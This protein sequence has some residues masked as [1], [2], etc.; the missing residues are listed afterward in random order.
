MLA[1]ADLERRIRHLRIESRRVVNDVL[2]G[3]Y[4][5]VFKGRGTEFDELR[6]YV[7]GDDIR[8]IDWNVTARTGDPYIKRCIEE[9]ELTVFFLVDVS[10]SGDFGSVGSSKTDAAARLVSLLAFA[11][12]QNNDKVGLLLFTDEVT[13]VIRPAKGHRHVLRLIREILAA[14]HGGKTDIAAAL[15][16]YA[17]INRRR[18]VT[19]V[20]SDFADSMNRK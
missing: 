12:E 3:E 16:H 17:K 4:R 9:R 13:Q 2:D 7:P 15:A 8:S 6:Q 5:S 20:L 11:A 14:P 19:F 10:A 18:S 1:E